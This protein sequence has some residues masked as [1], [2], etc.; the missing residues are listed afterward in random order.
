MGGYSNDKPDT[1]Y[2][3][4]ISMKAPIED[5]LFHILPQ[6]ADTSRINTIIALGLFIRLILI[7]ISELLDAWDI[8]DVKYTDIDYY[9]YTDAANHVY[10][11]NSPFLRH[12]YRYTPLIA[13]IC[14]PNI[15]LP[16]FGKIVFSLADVG[17]G[18]LINKLYNDKEQNSCSNSGFSGSKKSLL[19]LLLW[20]FNP[21]TL[22]V[23]TRGSA[24]AL[25]LCCVMSSVYFCLHRRPVATGICLGLAIHLKIYPIIYSLPFYLFISDSPVWEVTGSRFKLMFS[26]ISTTTIL[27]GTFFFLYGAEFLNEAYMYHISR[28]D[29]RHNFSLWFYTLY[30]QSGQGLTLLMRVGA[31]LPQALVQLSTALRYANDPIACCYFQT[32]LFVAFNKVATSQYFLWFLPFYCLLGYRIPITRIASWFAA[33]GFWLLIAYHIEFKGMALFLPLFCACALLFVSHLSLACIPASS[34]L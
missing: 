15:W 7:F 4:Q 6:L 23:S 32:L 20:L 3:S 18:L 17:V 5:R 25:I 12:T 24:E 33:Q 26:C 30:L 22:G 10:N 9:V 2:E 29:I 8:T 21:L 14:I 34:K 31:F 27:S 16:A 13:Y 1:S 28:G 19:P 11:L